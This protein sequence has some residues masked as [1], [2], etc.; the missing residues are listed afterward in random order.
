MRLCEAV[1]DWC[2]AEG[3]MVVELEV[4]AGSVG[5]SDCMRGWGLEGSGVRRDIIGTR[6]MTPFDAAGLSEVAEVA[7][8]SFVGGGK[9]FCQ[10]T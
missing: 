5:R 7:G 9:A 10:F 8:R 6:W 1:V 3:A 2:R 4:R